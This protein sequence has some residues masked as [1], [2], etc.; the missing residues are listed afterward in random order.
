[1]TIA[2]EYNPTKCR[3]DSPILVTINNGT[4][5]TVKSV[6][7]RLQAFEDGRS[8]DLIS[9]LDS[10]SVATQVIQPAGTRDSCWRLGGFKRKVT[11]EVHLRPEKEWPGATFYQEG[12]FIPASTVSPKEAP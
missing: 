11:N 1:V 5:K 6:T 2:A 3:S 9:S 8:D 7:F 12:E 10:D 4:S